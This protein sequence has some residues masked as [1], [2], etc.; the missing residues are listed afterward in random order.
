MKAGS[1]NYQDY[2]DRL[3][4]EAEALKA[5]G[6]YIKSDPG[7]LPLPEDTKKNF[8]WLNKEYQKGKTEVKVEVKGEGSSFKPGYDLQ[9]DLKSVKD[10]KPGMYGDVKTGDTGKKD[11]PLPRG[12]EP[13]SPKN[14]GAAPP[15]SKAENKD[16]KGGKE[17]ADNQDKKGNIAPKKQ[18]IEGDM[19]SKKKKVNEE[20]EVEEEVEEGL[21]GNVVRT[22]GSLA[23]DAGGAIDNVANANSVCGAIGGLAR[24]AGNA[25]DNAAN[26]L[27]NK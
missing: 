9:T 14:K 6:G 7:G 25:V 2:L 4:E 20:E 13:A 8:D 1:Y 24:D 12:E 5:D 23:R 11:G 21:V 10:F 15:D 19:T 18:A 26:K 3:H 16:P 22:A 17:A 27:F